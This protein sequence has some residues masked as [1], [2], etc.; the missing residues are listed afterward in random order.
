MCRIDNKLCFVK[1][2]FKDRPGQLRTS[3]FFFSP[4]QIF[5]LYSYLSVNFYHTKSRYDSHF[6]ANGII[7]MQVREM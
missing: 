4:S 6:V 3:L 2:G 1:S 5:F 7:D